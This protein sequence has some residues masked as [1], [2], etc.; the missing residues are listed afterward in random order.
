MDIDI[1]IRE[2]ETFLGL[3]ICMNNLK[4]KNLLTKMILFFTENY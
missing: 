4:P 2:M 3:K 1:K